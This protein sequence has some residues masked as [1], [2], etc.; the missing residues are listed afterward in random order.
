MWSYLNPGA[1]I[2]EHKRVAERVYQFVKMILSSLGIKI[3][4][5]NSDLTLPRVLNRDRG[6]ENSKS[7]HKSQV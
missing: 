4:F 5:K 1:Y 7:T 2:V 6:L 3:Y